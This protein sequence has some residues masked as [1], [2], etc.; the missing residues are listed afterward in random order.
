MI[1][2]EYMQH[3]RGIIIGIVLS[4]IGIFLCLFVV[5]FFTTQHPFGLPNFSKVVKLDCGLTI[6]APKENKSISFPYK[7]YGYANG[8][9]WDPV[10]GHIGTLSVLTTRGILLQ[11]IYIDPVTIGDGKPYYFESY[12][13][14][15]ISFFDETGLF[16]F[17]N[18]PSPFSP[19]KHIEINVRFDHHL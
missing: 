8:C 15:P 17:E 7:V 13:S 12:I 6:Y 16:V 9:G 14:V 3:N 4:L 5:G 11:K 10:D 2:F 18:N 19:Q 1:Y